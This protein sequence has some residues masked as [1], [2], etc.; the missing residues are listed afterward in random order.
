M[1]RFVEV[2]LETWIIMLFSYHIVLAF[3][4]FLVYMFSLYKKKEIKKILNKKHYS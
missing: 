3:D 1:K 2:F 4:I